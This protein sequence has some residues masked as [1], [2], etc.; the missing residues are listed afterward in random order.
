MHL[1]LSEGIGFLEQS[2]DSQ[3]QNLTQMSRVKSNSKETNNAKNEPDMLIE[4]LQDTFH[5]IEK[6]QINKENTIN[7][8]PIIL[9]K[10]H[11]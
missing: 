3:L 1:L 4:P 9:K 5:V 2:F 6:E 7:D 10:N 11:V 8:L